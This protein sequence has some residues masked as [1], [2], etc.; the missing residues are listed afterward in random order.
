MK[1][2]VSLMNRIVIRTLDGSTSYRLKQLAWQEGLPLE[3]MA[4]LLLIKAVHLRAALRP[5]EVRG[6]GVAEAYPKTQSVRD[7]RFDPAEL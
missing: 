4:R 6:N 2:L 3:D 5:R 7:R 1:I